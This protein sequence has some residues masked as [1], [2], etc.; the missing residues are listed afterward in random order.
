[1]LVLGMIHVGK[2][3]WR[4]SWSKE[5]ARPYLCNENDLDILVVLLEQGVGDVKA[6]HGPAEDDY[7]LD[8]V[9]LGVFLCCVVCVCVCVIIFRIEV[10]RVKV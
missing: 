4:F 8:H 2:R 5:E 9:L 10:R 3:A 1:M 6:A 7:G